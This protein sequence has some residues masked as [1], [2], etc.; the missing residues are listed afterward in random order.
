[1][2]A[3]FFIRQNFKENFFKDKKV[4]EVNY[5]SIFPY[6]SVISD[7]INSLE[8]TDSI[9]NKIKYDIIRWLNYDQLD[10]LIE[11]IYDDAKKEIIKKIILQEN[12]K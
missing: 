9:L 12:Y 11:S 3:L 10:D 2:N 7:N 8:L 1:M 5:K 6:F 4:E